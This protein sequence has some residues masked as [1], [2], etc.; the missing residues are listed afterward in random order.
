MSQTGCRAALTPRQPSAMR[1]ASRPASTHVSDGS[2]KEA[3]AGVETGVIRKLKTANA[4]HPGPRRRRVTT[5]DVGLGIHQAFRC[6]PGSRSWSTYGGRNTRRGG[7]D[8][9]AGADEEGQSSQDPAAAILIHRVSVSLSCTWHNITEGSVNLS[10]RIPLT[11]G[12]KNNAGSSLPSEPCPGGPSKSD[13]EHLSQ[14]VDMRSRVVSAFRR[15]E[16][17]SSRSQQSTSSPIT[18]SHQISPTCLRGVDTGAEEQGWGWQS[19]PTHVEMCFKPSSPAAVLAMCDMSSAFLRGAKELAMSVLNRHP[20]FAH[21]SFDR[22]TFGGGH[23]KK[24][25]RGV[26]RPSHLAWPVPITSARGTH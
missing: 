15:Q 22:H 16:F 6:E 9:S 20:S 11:A 10:N 19:L 24:W 18:P 13:P 25:Q 4:R 14:G 21:S 8:P 26:N 23:P 17:E 12:S 2:R 1:S 5:D 7:A 3:E